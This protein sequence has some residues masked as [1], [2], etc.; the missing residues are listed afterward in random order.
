MSDT[1]VYAGQRF[2]GAVELAVT[3]EPPA[4]G[5]CHC[6]VCRAWFAGP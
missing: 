6:A 1:N 2:C 3:G 4:M 5:Y